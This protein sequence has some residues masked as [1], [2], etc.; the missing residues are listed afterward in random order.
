MFPELAAPR[1][2][3]SKVEPARVVIVPAESVTV[4]ARRP[5][6]ANITTPSTRV[7]RALASGIEKDAAEV[8]EVEAFALI[9]KSFALVPR[10]AD[11]PCVFSRA[12]KLTVRFPP[13]EFVIPNV[14]VPA[15][16]F[17]NFIFI[18]TR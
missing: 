7:D 14:T 5:E 9:F 16:T 6:V 11:A 4:K 1:S 17:V 3:S 18:A 8:V 10:V 15:V 2:V 13:A 12:V